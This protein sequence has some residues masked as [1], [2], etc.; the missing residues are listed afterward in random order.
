MKAC[1]PP[2]PG[3]SGASAVLPELCTP[4]CPREPACQ[5][6]WAQS[7]CLLVMTCF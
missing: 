1:S 7:S 4:L 3:D 5:V 6:P 2:S